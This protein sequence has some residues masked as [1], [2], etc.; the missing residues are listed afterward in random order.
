MLNNTPESLSLEVEFRASGEKY[1]KLQTPMVNFT[2]L[3]D[4]KVIN[5]TACYDC[6]IYYHLFRYC[7][8]ICESLSSN[9]FWVQLLNLYWYKCHF[10]EICLVEYSCSSHVH[11]LVS[12]QSF[13]SNIEV[14]RFPLSFWWPPWLRLNKS[15][16]R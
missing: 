11:C 5:W 3:Q 1:C 14:S 15:N 16:V 6:F 12:W 2:E 10:R 8:Q 7:I 9:A 4:R 13:T